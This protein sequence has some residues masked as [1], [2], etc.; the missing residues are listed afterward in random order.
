ML[1]F[2]WY[3]QKCTP[4]QVLTHPDATNLL[5]HGI[6]KNTKT[7]I[8]WERTITFL[9]NKKIPIL[10]LRWP[11]LRSY[12]FVEEVVFKNNY[13]N[14]V[15]KNWKAIQNQIKKVKKCKD[16]SL[17]I[18][19]CSENILVSMVKIQIPVCLKK[20]LLSK[21]SFTKLKISNFVI[22]SAKKK[23]KVTNFL[24]MTNIFPD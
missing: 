22:L 19:Q 21:V 8:S 23:W 13:K 20:L 15:A 4:S 1:R 16:H 24:M 7:W 5:N 11:I 2:R 9:W 14:K 6:V 3:I 10:C 17:Q 12:R 18:T